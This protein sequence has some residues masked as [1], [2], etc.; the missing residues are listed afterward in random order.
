MTSSSP[1][2][3]SPRPLTEVLHKASTKTKDSKRHKTLTYTEK[4]EVCKLIDTGQ[5]KR[6]VGQKF[7]INESIMCRI[8][9]KK[10]HIELAPNSAESNAKQSPNHILLKTEEILSWYMD[11]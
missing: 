7:G 6:N 9:L 8:Y 2:A 10:A 4:W 3:T 1:P 5:T 11:K